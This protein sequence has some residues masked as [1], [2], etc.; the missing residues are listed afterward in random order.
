MLP[1]VMMPARLSPGGVLA[2]TFAS[3]SEID[4]VEQIDHMGRVRVDNADSPVGDTPVC[5]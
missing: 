5:E 2:R 3:S 1:G 4:C